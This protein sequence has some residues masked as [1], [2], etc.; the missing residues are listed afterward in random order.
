ML[1]SYTI[2]KYMYRLFEKFTFKAKEKIN[3][4]NEVTRAG[5]RIRTEMFYFSGLFYSLALFAV[6]SEF[7]MI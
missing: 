3:R 6:L 2:I 4:A 7:E 5:L 1:A